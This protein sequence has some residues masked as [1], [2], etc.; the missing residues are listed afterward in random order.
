MCAKLAIAKAIIDAERRSL[1][2]IDPQK[3]RDRPLKAASQSWLAH[4]LRDIT[5]GHRS[6][7]LEDAFANLTVVNFNY[8]RCFEHFTY[9]WL[10]NFYKLTEQNAATLVRGISVYHP[11]G[12]IAPLGWEDPSTGVAYGSSIDTHSLIAMSNRIRTYSE[13]FEPDSGLI[14]VRERLKKASAAVFLGFGF[15]KQNMDILSIGG[16]LTSENLHLYCT[17]SGIP[18]PKWAIVLDRVKLSF[19]RISTGCIID[20]SFNA[21]CE[22]FWE[23]YSDVILYG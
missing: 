7:R 15:H 2:Y 21:H 8:D 17:K 9:N 5:R 10:Q 18:N 1:L 23:E 3:S 4:F 13:V 12:R 20:H 14:Q 19:S 22:E 6:D 11:Y 16:P